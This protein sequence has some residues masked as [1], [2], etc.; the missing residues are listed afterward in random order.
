MPKVGK[1][2]N[3]SDL[4]NKLLVA[5]AAFLSRRS[6]RD[7]G[8]NRVPSNQWSSHWRGARWRL[9]MQIVSATFVC[10]ERWGKG[11][12]V[13]R[14]MTTVGSVITFK[15][16]WEWNIHN[17]SSCRTKTTPACFQS[18][19]KWFGGKFKMAQ[20]HCT[21]PRTI[22]LARRG[23]VT[24]RCNWK[25]LQFWA[26]NTA[27]FLLVVFFSRFQWCFRSSYSFSAPF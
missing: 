19:R 6:Q 5:C 12:L 25:C 9:G 10:A 13:R 2:I 24:L 23:R 4:Q 18:R 8:S 17:F 11:K 21:E 14:D 22:W 15:A 7:S 1:S 20:H 3:R 27:L 26:N 16:R